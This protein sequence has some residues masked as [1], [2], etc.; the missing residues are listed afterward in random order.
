M[1]HKD[2]TNKRMK[3]RWWR[4]THTAGP[5][6]LVAAASTA[7]KG[8][9]VGSRGGSR[10]G[11]D[12]AGCCWLREGTQ[13]LL[14][15]LA[16]DTKATAAAAWG[17]CW[18]EK[19]E[20]G[21]RCCLRWLL[22]RGGKAAHGKR[23][24]EGEKGEGEGRKEKTACFERLGFCGSFIPLFFFYHN[25]NYYYYAYFIY[26]YLGSFCCEIQ[27]RGSPSRPHTF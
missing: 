26:F 9:K 20:G 17:G 21:C 24:E 12:G 18:C 6:L 14:L 16:R 22:V 2:G 19:N 3:T 25:N 27:L 23:E 5:W 11:A 1:A 4:R 10:R 7:E 13:P 8:G 15:P